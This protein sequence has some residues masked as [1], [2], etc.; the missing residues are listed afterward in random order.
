MN[1]AVVLAGLISGF[2]GFSGSSRSVMGIRYSDTYLEGHSG[3]YLTWV[4]LPQVSTWIF[5][6]T[7]VPAGSTWIFGADQYCMYVSFIEETYAIKYTIL[8]WS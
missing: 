1:K 7:W 6:G 3:K 5:P 8:N 2:S 4:N